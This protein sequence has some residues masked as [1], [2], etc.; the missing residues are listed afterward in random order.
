MRARILRASARQAVL[1]PTPRKARA[2]R[3]ARR[4]GFVAAKLRPRSTIC[5]QPA[6]GE[7]HHVRLRE[8]APEVR[9]SCRAVRSS[10]YSRRLPRSAVTAARRCSKGNFGW[11]F[12]RMAAPLAGSSP[13]TRGT[14]CPRLLED[15][16]AGE[17][18]GL[19][20]RLLVRRWHCADPSARS[21]RF[22]ARSASARR[23]AC[24][25]HEPRLRSAVP[26]VDECWSAVIAGLAMPQSSGQMHGRVV[27]TRRTPILSARL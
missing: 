17:P 21:R 14:P 25:A 9:N 11:L 16:A 4:T 1:S 27:S 10:K 8:C 22:A 6:S 12:S 20:V 24:L 23:G 3:S 18:S 5:S 26:A 7:R 13:K 15:R 19:I 2:V